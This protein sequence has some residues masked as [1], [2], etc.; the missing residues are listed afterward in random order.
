MDGIEERTTVLGTGEESPE[1]AG[2]GQLHSLN[3]SREAA[4]EITASNSFWEISSGENRL[5]F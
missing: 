3:I 1:F 5:K 2:G 4:V